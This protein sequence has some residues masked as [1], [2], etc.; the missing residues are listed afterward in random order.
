MNWQVEDVYDLDMGELAEAPEHHP[1]CK[2]PEDSLEGLSPNITWGGSRLSWT[3]EAGR[4]GHHCKTGHKTHKAKATSKAERA[5]VLADAI[6]RMRTDLEDD[7]ARQTIAAMTNEELANVVLGSGAQK[8]Q[9]LKHLGEILNV[10]L[11]TPQVDDPEQCPVG[12]GN[13]DCPVCGGRHAEVPIYMTGQTV[14]ELNRSL[15][16]LDKL[17]GQEG[18]GIS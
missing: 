16:A 4:F 3:D 6:G 7:E 2:R 17:V 10:G 18:N 1:M 14:S 15:Q 8:L 13:I 12:Q 9:G 11:G 5:K